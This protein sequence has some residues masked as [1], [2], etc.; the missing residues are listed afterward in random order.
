[1]F[2]SIA[3][4]KTT[5]TNFLLGD[6]CLSTIACFRKLGVLIEQNEKEVVIHGKGMEALQE[7]KDILDVGNSGTT[8]RLLTGILS[9]LPFHSTLIGDSSIGKRP[10]TRVVAP[11]RE[12]GQKL[13]AGKT[14][15]ILLY[16]FEA[17][18]YRVL[19]IDYQ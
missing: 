19:P 15:N 18:I 17:V 9:G 1:M 4:G 10:M 12:M 3:N 8:I 6:D 5:V 11:L 2:G 7:P 16:P 14:E 13:M